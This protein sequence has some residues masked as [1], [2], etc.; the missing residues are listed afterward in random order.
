MEWQP[1][2][3]MT[4][5]T[6][7]EMKADMGPLLDDILKDIKYNKFPNNAPNFTKFHIEAN[8]PEKQLKRNFLA[9]LRIMLNYLNQAKSDERQ[10]ILNELEDKYFHLTNPLEQSIQKYEALVFLRQYFP[11][12]LHED[13][14][15]PEGEDS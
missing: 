11:Q 5:A 14:R 6:D 9:H 2:M 8:L 13:Y 10:R 15:C 1:F 7:D 12:V 4:P 3:E